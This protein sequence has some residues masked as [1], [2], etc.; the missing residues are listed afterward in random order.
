MKIEI[1]KD[2]L[3]RLFSWEESREDLILDHRLTAFYKEWK[4]WDE[5]HLPTL[6]EGFDERLMSHLKDI[7]QAE[8]S[9]SNKWFPAFLESRSIQYGISFAMACILAV[10]LIGRSSNSF[11][12]END[13]TAGVV[14]KN[15]QY[16]DQPSSAEYA[17]SY[18]RRVFLE[19]V[20]KKEGAM[21]TLHGLETYFNATGKKGVAGEIRSFILEV[22]R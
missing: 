2:R 13:E 1:M 7:R 6:S 15:T 17:D 14:I 10:V 4:S 20:Q 16:L 12:E 8:E 18:H 21:E 9:F 3:R 11:M 19:S 5:A 22:K